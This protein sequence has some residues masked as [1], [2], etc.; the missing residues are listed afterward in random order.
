MNY[1][2]A[3]VLVVAGLLKIYDSSGMIETLN[4][5]PFLNRIAVDIMASIVPMVE[6]GFGIA[7]V[8]KYEPAII[9]TMTAGLF[10]AFLVFS[11]YG[12]LSGF[13]GGCGCFG[14]IAQSIFGWEMILRNLL[15]FCAAGL[16][17]VQNRNSKSS[18]FGINFN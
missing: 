5:I 12:Y 14:G 17:L 4:Q 11:I 3:G 9:L 6:L 7:L 10:L 1:L 2:L 8:A 15:L 13:Q 18:R 16:L